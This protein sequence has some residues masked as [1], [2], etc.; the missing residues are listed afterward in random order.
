[1]SFEKAK[2][3]KMPGT[4][5]TTTTEKD[6]VDTDD[7]DRQACAAP[8]STALSARAAP[9]SVPCSSQ[10][11]MMAHSAAPAASNKVFG[12]QDNGTARP[13]LSAGQAGLAAPDEAKGV[14]Q[15][16]LEPANALY[17]NF[18][19]GLCNS[20]VEPRMPAVCRLGP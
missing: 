10:D 3:A 2:E 20:R 1:M 19:P 11:T 18:G 4:T 5:G 7:T 15:C 13:D 16:I 9:R 8:N 12:P 17:L 6:V 14:T